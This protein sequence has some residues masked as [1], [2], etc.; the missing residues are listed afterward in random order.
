MT[1]DPFLL[2]VLVCPDSE[3]AVHLATPE[4]LE[5]MNQQIKRRRLKTVGGELVSESLEAALVR[6]DGQRAYAILDDVPVMLV[7][8]GIVLVG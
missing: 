2:T 4:Q 1:I 3:Q 5:E 7:D 8:E 6:E